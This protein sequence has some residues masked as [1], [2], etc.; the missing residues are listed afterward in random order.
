MHQRPRRRD[1]LDDVVIARAAAQ[2]AFQAMADLLFGWATFLVSVVPRAQFDWL[3]IGLGVTA[4][5]LFLFGTHRFL[6]WWMRST[7]SLEAGASPVHWKFA[8]SV[9]CVG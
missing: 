7:T 6:Q 2:I 3:A 1:R 4:A 9:A 5:S 8:W